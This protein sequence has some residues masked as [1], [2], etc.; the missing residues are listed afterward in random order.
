MV[1]TVFLLDAVYCNLTEVNN[2]EHQHSLVVSSFY[3]CT[4]VGIPCALRLKQSFVCFECELAVLFEVVPHHL[5]S[6]PFPAW[7]FLAGLPGF[8]SH[9][10]SLHLGAGCQ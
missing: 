6:F 7:G 8:A 3:I 1:T 4:C 9:W 2:K 5:G 10:S